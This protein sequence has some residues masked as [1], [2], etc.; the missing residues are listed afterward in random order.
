MSE[1]AKDD[2]DYDHDDDKADHL[3]PS[4]DPDIAHLKTNRDEIMKRTRYAPRATRH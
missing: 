2:Q 4:S 1:I 3:A